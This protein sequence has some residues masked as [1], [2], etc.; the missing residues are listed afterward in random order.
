MY[1]FMAKIKKG[2]PLSFDFNSRDLANRG[3]FR[4]EV[5]KSRYHEPFERKLTW[6]RYVGGNVCITNG[7]IGFGDTIVI[8]CVEDFLEKSVF[9]AETL[10]ATV[11][12]FG[13]SSNA[14]ELTLC[15]WCEIRNGSEDEREMSSIQ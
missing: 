7:S 1:M 6:D 8:F 11:S 10:Q 4:G 3:K 14:S 15:C 9:S 12:L 5:D 13:R 2:E